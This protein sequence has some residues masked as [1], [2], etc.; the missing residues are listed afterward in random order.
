MN[1]AE[2][3]SV[4]TREDHSQSM[5]PPICNKILKII[6]LSTLYGEEDLFGYFSYKKKIE[7]KKFLLLLVSGQKQYKPNTE[8]TKY[9][10]LC[11]KIL[12]GHMK[13]YYDLGFN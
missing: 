2:L 8:S 10:V 1:K 6:T 12:C 3:G 4:G 9:L 13:G 7:N 11:W 5:D